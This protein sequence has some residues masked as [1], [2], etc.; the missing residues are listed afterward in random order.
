MS[1]RFDKRER[2][3]SLVGQWLGSGLT[4][5]VYDFV[6]ISTTTVGASSQLTITFNSI[7]STYKHLQIRA[8]ALSASNSVPVLLRFNSDTGSNYSQ[9]YFAG[10]GALVSS[11]GTA[12]TSSI[13]LTGIYARFLDPSNPWSFVIDI[14]DYANTNKYK[15]VRSFHGAD[16]NGSGEINLTSGNWRSTSAISTIT[17]SMAS[18]GFT[19]YSQFALYGIT[20]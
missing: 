10:Q 17:L 12:S 19:Q 20:G 13:T 9:H 8:I 3:S 4:D 5:P 6:S 16:Y 15:T 14:L 18:S 7:P 11:G 2:P 1:D